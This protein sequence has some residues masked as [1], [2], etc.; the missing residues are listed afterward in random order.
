MG[1]WW[2]RPPVYSDL[3]AGGE[4]G[5]EGW[6]AAGLLRFRGT[7]EQT[8]TELLMW[9]DGASVNTVKMKHV[10]IRSRPAPNIGC[11][12]S[13]ARDEDVVNYKSGTVHPGGP[14]LPR[15]FQ[16][17]SGKNRNI[18]KNEYEQNN[19]DVAFPAL[20][21]YRRILMWITWFIFGFWS[22]FLMRTE[23]SEGPAENARVWPSRLASFFCVCW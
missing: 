19:A 17:S 1:G 4:A 22:G 8:I 12:V 20:P 9:N 3:W 18:I 16:S 13:A 23:Q 6:S 15:V 7:H 10:L 21:C 5:R 2:V 11:F 14:S